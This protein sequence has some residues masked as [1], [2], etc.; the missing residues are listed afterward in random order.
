[1][2][3]SA[4]LPVLA[5]ALLLT[6]AS[7]PKPSDAP[8]GVPHFRLLEPTSWLIE[9]ERGDPQ[10]TGP[11]GGSNTDWGDP[12]YVVNHA[13]GGD[14]LHIKVQ[15]TIYHPGHYRLALAV[16][17]PNELPPDPEAVTRDTERGPVSVSAAIQNPPVIPVLADGLFAHHERPTQQQVFETDVRLPNINCD[18]CVLQVVQFMEEH[19]FNNPGGYTYHHCAMMQITADASKPIDQGWPAER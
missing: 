10:K 4:R 1:M 17:S 11:C 8:N 13:V 6:G 5:A 12:S 2:G 3:S 18:H 19:G 14:F 15:E 16:N 7:A 9:D